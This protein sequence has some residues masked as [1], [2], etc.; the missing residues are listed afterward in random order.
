MTA[1]VSTLE[2][3]VQWSAKRL[4]LVYMPGLVYY[5]AFTPY[6]Y[7]GGS[8]VL[9]RLVFEVPLFYGLQFEQLSCT[10]HADP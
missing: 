8:L 9:R 5:N 7:C 3:R 4:C 10:N 2:L 6:S 1:P